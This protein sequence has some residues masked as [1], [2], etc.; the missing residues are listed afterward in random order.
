MQDWGL[1]TNT[2]NPTS[3]HVNV[4]TFLITGLNWQ[5]LKGFNIKID[6]R[7]LWYRLLWKSEFNWNFSN[8]S[9]NHLKLKSRMQARH[10]LP[11]YC[12]TTGHNFNKQRNKLV[13]IYL[14]SCSSYHTG[15]SQLEKN[16][17]AILSN[18]GFM[19]LHNTQSCSLCL[20]DLPHQSDK[21]TKSSNCDSPAFA[22][23]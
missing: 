9:E 16:I 5:C 19:W 22:F 12:S 15:S 3:T 11:K 20:I 18:H 14:Y 23:M 7:E 8:W 6:F 1:C 4:I 2:W 17:F 21:M 10:D 13:H